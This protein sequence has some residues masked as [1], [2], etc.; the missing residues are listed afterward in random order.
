[1]GPEKPVFKFPHKENRDGSYDSICPVCFETV[2]TVQN[3]FELMAHEA[4]HVCRE[5]LLSVNS[6]HHSHAN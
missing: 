3:E 2:A 5:F 6:S 1:M 4:K